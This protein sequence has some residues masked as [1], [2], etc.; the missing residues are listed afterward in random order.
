MEVDKVEAA[1][2]AEAVAVLPAQAYAPVTCHRQNGKPG[3]H[4]RH[5]F[6]YTQ[7][8]EQDAQSQ[9]QRSGQQQQ[10]KSHRGAACRRGASGFML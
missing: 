1:E 9:Q 2:E 10:Q 8:R 7:Y 6:Q 5:P 3:R 4:C